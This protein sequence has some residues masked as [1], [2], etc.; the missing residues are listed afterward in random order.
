MRAVVF[1]GPGRPLEGDHWPTPAPGRGQ[2]LIRVKACGI[3]GSD[4]H[5]VESERT[6][7]NIVMGHEMGGIIAALGEGV[8]RWHVGQ[9]VAPL[10]QISCGQCAACRSNRSSDCAKLEII[11]FNP[12]YNG[13]Y[14]EYV[15]V[16]EGDVLPLPD[17]VGFDEAAV[18]EPLAVGL[19][20]VRR[21]KLQVSEA[22]LILGAG[23]IGLAIAIWAR[24]FGAA[25]IV[26]SEPHAHRR[27]LALQVGATAVIDPAAE[28]ELLTAV[29]ARTG[30]PVAVL[31]EAVG[32][33]GMVRTCIELAAPRSRVVF[34]GFCQTPETLDVY[35]CTFKALEL[36]FPFGYSVAD[37]AFIL[38]AI[39]QGRVSA[40]PL[41]SHRISL[42]EVPAMFESL[43]HPTDHCKVIVEP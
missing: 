15:I 21:A 19:D 24:F 3:C 31:F 33:P 1:R 7:K 14:A 43:R 34:A 35:D 32:L 13:G 38:T 12:R 30:S 27:A 4:L 18:L 17:S 6:P 20:A 2:L 28:T 41:I 39:G 42:D 29:L 37:Y 25:H 23:P 9:R 8:D 16:G 36:I 11:A 10:S 40:K 5:A 26:V 22:V